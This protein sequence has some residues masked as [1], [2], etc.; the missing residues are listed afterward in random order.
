MPNTSTVK[1]GQ[2]FL[3]KVLQTTGS[4]EGA[5]E[6]ALLNGIG[7]TEDMVT[8]SQ[9]IP[10]SIDKK[11]IVSFWQPN[12]KEPATALFNE[13]ETLKSGIDYWAIDLDFIVQ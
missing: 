12:I 9:I 3:D 8:A 11:N 2:C 10:Y 4:F 7:I 13:Y 1:Q 6:M 5:F